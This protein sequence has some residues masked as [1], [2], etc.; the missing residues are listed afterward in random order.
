MSAWS[1]FGLI[2]IAAGIGMAL[3]FVWCR[4]IRNY[5]YVDAIWAFMLGLTG[6][7]AAWL[8]NGSLISRLLV[9]VFSA[10]WALRLGLHLVQR[11]VREP[12]DG[13]Y[14][15]LRTALNDRPVPIFL[16]FQAQALTVALFSLPFFAA[17]QS[18]KISIL[19]ALLAVLVWT[20]AW[21]GETLADRQ[22]SRWRSNP[23]NRG[24]TCRRGLWAWSRHPN[25]FF[26]W[27]HWFAYLI[28]AASGPYFALSWI[29]PVVMLLFVYRISGI[30]WVEAQAV[31]SRGEDYKKY[32][33]E[34]SALFP[35]P[36]RKDAHN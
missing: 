33:R 27:L 18:N 14:Q 16:F 6:L 8:S 15:A 10:M 19:Q 25:Y 34:V 36:P 28:L 3:S 35:W 22:L 11:I 31:K 26:E 4:S 1:F 7:A 13:R 23:D 12:E 32:Q 29:G 30:P 24:K 20:L 2:W 5:A 21:G 9:V 17:A